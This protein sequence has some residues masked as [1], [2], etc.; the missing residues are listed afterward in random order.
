[1]QTRGGHMA[2]NIHHSG[3]RKSGGGSPV[4][5]RSILKGLGLA[6]GSGALGLAAPAVRAAPTSIVSWASAGQ[7]WEFPQRGVYPLFQKKFPDIKVQIVA[8]PIADM[9]PKTA[10]ATGSKKHRHDGI[11]DARKLMT[12]F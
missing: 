2:R 10:V 8:E 4:P 5:R 1:M 3:Q 9:L 12:P 11:P 7:R 6:V